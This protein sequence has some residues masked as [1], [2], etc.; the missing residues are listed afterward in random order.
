MADLN[1]KHHTKVTAL[2]LAHT[3]KVKQLNLAHSTEVNQ[4][5]QA[6]STEVGHINSLHSVQVHELNDEMQ[7]YRL[8]KEAEISRINAAHEEARRRMQNQIDIL[9]RSLNETKLIVQQKETIICRLEN[10]RN[11]RLD[12]E[13]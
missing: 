8:E 9:T 6:H 10:E 7:A 2:N 13:Q 4:L 1:A 5:N 12:V 11:I 3:T